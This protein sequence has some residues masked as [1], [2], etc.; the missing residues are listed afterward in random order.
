MLFNQFSRTAE[1]AAALRAW[2]AQTAATRKLFYD[3]HAMALTSARWRSVL[4]NPRR[5]RLVMDGLL[6]WMQPIAVQV[7]ARS[8]HAERV[9]QQAVR[10]GVTQYVI[11]GAGL[12]SF[13][14]RRP[15]WARDIAVFE[16]DHPATQAMKQRRC[17]A[18]GLKG[19]PHW[20][21]CNF[22]RESVAEAL[23]RSAF[24]SQQA[25]C[26]VW[27]GV[28]HYLKPEA[29]HDTILA[30]AGVA[31]AGSELVFDYSLPPTKISRRDWPLAAGLGLLTAALGE[32]LL[33]G[34]APAT[35]RLWAR[36]AGWAVVD[37]MSGPPAA[38]LQVPE[39]TR[40]A[41]WQRRS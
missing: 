9:L 23:Q 33:G 7:L 13:H 34:L 4:Q 21:A 24:D 30:L 27:L 14:W 8:H 25:A 37:D 3:P 22:E 28:T 10:R 40:L 36:E 38:G 11:V 15:A 35:L 6:R 17:A 2:G 29:T 39:V 19:T 32:P 26:F 1:A 31:A 12:D 18:V 41:H 20:V 5:R 16:V